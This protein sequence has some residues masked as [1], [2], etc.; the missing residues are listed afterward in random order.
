MI[1]NIF[2]D[3]VSIDAEALKRVKCGFQIYILL[4]DL[5]GIYDDVIDKLAV[6]ENRALTVQDPAPLK[7]D[8]LVLIGLLRKHLHRICLS[9]IPVYEE[10]PYS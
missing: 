4:E 9:V 2:L 7:G 8:R 3:A 5:L 1:G 10:K 6:R